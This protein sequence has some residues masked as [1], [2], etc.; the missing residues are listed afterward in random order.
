MDTIIEMQN[1]GCALAMFYIVAMFLIMVA[2]YYT[3]TFI[4]WRIYLHN[5]GKKGYFTYLHIKEL[6]L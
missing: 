2:I 5:G 4:M 1:V 6:E 3:F